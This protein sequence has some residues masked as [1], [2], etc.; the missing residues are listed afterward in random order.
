MRLSERRA[1]SVRQYL[2]KRGVSPE[3]LVAKGYGPTQPVIPDAKTKE[4]LA[5]NRRVQFAI[6]PAIEVEEETNIE[7]DAVIVE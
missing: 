1:K 4:E 6:P 5:Q 3:R 7:V 2:I